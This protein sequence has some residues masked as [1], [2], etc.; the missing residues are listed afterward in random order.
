MGESRL[1]KK[2]YNMLCVL[3]TRGKV[4]WVTKVRVKLYESGFGH[5]WVNQ[6]VGNIS[7]FIRM[8][9]ARL[10]DCRWQNWSS[11]IQDSDRFYVYKQFNSLHC[12]P[13]Y[14]SMNIDKYLKSI[15]TK[16]RFGIS[17]IAA[18]YLRYRQHCDRDLICPLCKKAQETEV[19][20]VLCCPAL[21]D[22]RNDFIPRK[23]H[24]QAYLF[25]LILLMASCQ[26]EVVKR[27]TIYLHKAF[28]IRSL[29]C[30]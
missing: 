6:G 14:L 22:L 20:F 10:I 23:F 7:G 12:V 11:H 30:T 29:S 19:H 25:K 8:L 2:A 27:F 9:R 21:V 17:D 13:T 26:E 15:M 3:D 28:R 5:V 4:N 24:S 1:P 16:F 18:H